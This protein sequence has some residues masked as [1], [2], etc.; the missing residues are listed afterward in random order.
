[1]TSR[2][3]SDFDPFNITI[4]LDQFD[5]VLS[6]PH[7][8]DGETTLKALNDPRVY[9]NLEGPPYPYTPKDRD[10]WYKIVRD[11]ADFHQQQWVELMKN[12]AD[13][14]RGDSQKDAAAGS[15]HRKWVGG[16]QWASTIRAKVRQ[17]GPVAQGTTYPFIGEITVR[18]SGFPYIRDTE[19][20]RKTV[21]VNAEL[22]PGDPNIV[23]EVGFYLIPEYHG[24]GIMSVVLTNLR[25]QFLVPYMN[26]HRLIGTYFEHNVPSRRVFEKCGFQFLTFVPKGATLAQSKI[27]A[28]GLKDGEIGIGVME[29]QSTGAA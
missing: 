20:R 29:W 22:P 18:R 16:G 10:T 2:S 8:S 12:R 28:S 21:G 1:M 27:D 5:L 25:D 23:W 24:K 3:T 14:I 15:N 9:M 19:V 13:D 6:V 17:S 26:V 4:P 7:Q 11:G